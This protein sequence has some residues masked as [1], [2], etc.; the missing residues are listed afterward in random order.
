LRQSLAIQ[1]I[2]RFEIDN[3]GRV[4]GRFITIQKN[5]PFQSGEE[6]ALR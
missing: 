1:G 4:A 2:D 3:A 6:P 5:Y